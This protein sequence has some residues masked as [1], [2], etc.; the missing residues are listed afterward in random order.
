MQFLFLGRH[1]EGCSPEAIQG[2]V[3]N[4]WIVSY[5]YTSTSCLMNQTMSHHKSTSCF[6][7]HFV[8]KKTKSHHKSTS[9][10]MNQTMSPAMMIWIITL[11]LTCAPVVRAWW[12][13]LESRVVA[14]KLDT[15]SWSM[16]TPI[17]I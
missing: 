12:V 14:E 13:D 8:H 1:C 15:R 7:I 16:V 17:Y 4:L 2:L 9:C 10:L 3:T 6:L 11:N 5:Y